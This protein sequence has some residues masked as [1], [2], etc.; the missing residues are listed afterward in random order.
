M[1]NNIAFSC[2]CHGGGMTIVM[3][4]LIT[5]SEVPAMAV[6]TSVVAMTDQGGG[7]PPV[8]ARILAC[9]PA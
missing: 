3:I 6:A 5:I 7:N 1:Q 2:G 9:A 8:I 4:F